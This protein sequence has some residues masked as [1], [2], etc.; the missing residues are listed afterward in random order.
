M[1]FFLET[2]ISKLAKLISFILGWL[3]VLIIRG[4]E[5]TFFMMIRITSLMGRAL[6]WIEI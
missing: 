3:L 2:K 4:Q 1:H 6:T 5:V